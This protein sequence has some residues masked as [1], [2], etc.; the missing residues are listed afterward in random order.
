MNLPQVL[1]MKI[2]NPINAI[3]MIAQRLQKEFSPAG[4]NEEFSSIT[5]LLRS[6][7]TRINKIIKQFLDY[8]KPL[9][10]K[11]E[12][13]DSDQYF[14]QVYYLFRTQADK[15]RITFTMHGIDPGSIRIDPELMKQ[16]LMNLVQ[17]AFDAVGE[18]GSIN[19]EYV[20]VNNKLEIV[21]S[22]NG[23]GIPEENRRKIFDLY[24]TSRKDGT[25]IGLSITQK[26]IEQHGGIISFESAVNEGTK[27]KVVLPQ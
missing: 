6:E 12:E 5:S 3:G 2:R 10:M 4:T 16:A 9:E 23:K 17:N 24:Y 7:V 8:A 1:L 22:D 21:V 20:R 19:V 26:I 14:R 18:E 13:V 11:S 15:R 25:G 27:F